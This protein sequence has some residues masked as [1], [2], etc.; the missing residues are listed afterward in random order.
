MLRKGSSVGTAVTYMVCGYLID[1]LGWESVF[2]ITGLIGLLWHGLWTYVV[3]DSPNTHPTISEKERKYID[4]SLG[5]DVVK[6]VSV[7]VE[8]NFFFLKNRI[9]H[10]LRV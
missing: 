8:I 4:E 10:L 7:R 1:S 6:N 3:Y 9:D 5:N 2:Y